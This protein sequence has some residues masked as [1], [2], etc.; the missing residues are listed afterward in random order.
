MIETLMIPQDLIQ[1]YENAKKQLQNEGYVVNPFREI[2]YGIQFIVFFQKKSGLIRVFKSKKGIKWDFSQVETQ[3]A[4]ELRMILKTPLPTTLVPFELT[5]KA[6]AHEDLNSID[7]IIGIDESGKG[8][9]FGPLVAAAVHITPKSKKVLQRLG[10]MD[11]KELSDAYIEEISPE[12]KKVCYHSLVI[13]GNQSYNDIYEKVKNLNHILAW[14]HA[15]VL[16]N[17][18]KQ[19]DCGYALSDQ[20]GNPALV[21]NALMQ[22]GR[23]IKLFQ[24]PKA[25]S[26]LAVAA[27]SILARNGY[28]AAMRK[29]EAAFDMRFPKGCSIETKRAAKAFVKRY[30][31]DNLPLVAKVHFKVTEEL[32]EV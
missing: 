28:V 17:V 6:D 16:E 24:Q 26:H 14:G 8:D 31:K 1:L 22:K 29:M 20:F 21:Q 27:A 7:T 30:G 15:R 11:S 23:E 2:Q 5:K 10:V 19:V 4:Q 32:E 25:E 12:I 13:M 3:M 18:L 9:Y